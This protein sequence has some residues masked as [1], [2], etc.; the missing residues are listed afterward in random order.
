M[1]SQRTKLVL[2]DLGNPDEIK[3]QPDTVRRMVLGTLVGRAG[4]FIER[5]NPKDGEVMEGLTG[6]FRSIPANPEADQ[7]E[8][9]VLFIPDAFHNLIAS[10]LREAKKADANAVINFAFEVAS[11]R[12]TNPQGRSWDFKPM[13]DAGEENPLDKLVSALG[14]LQI[15]KDGRRVLAL[16][17]PA[18]DEKKA[19]GAKK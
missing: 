18:S 15:G 9:G 5:T 2:K 1:I 7:L 3:S 8:S 13:I 4:G 16:A 11:V 10:K 6:E 12:A 14:T 19:A 17:A